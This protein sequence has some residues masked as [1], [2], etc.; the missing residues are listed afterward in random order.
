MNVIPESHTDLLERP[1]FAVQAQEHHARPEGHP[2]RQ[3]P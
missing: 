2:L 3:R 1:L